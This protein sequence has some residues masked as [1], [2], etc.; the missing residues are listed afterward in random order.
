MASRSGALA[1]DSRAVRVARQPAVAGDCL[2]GSLGGNADARA[3]SGHIGN[4][5]LV[6][7]HRA[8]DST[9]LDVCATLAELK[10]QENRTCTNSSF[11]Y[12]FCFL[13]KYASK[14]HLQQSDA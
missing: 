1:S 8:G 13:G 2:I 10:Y 9:A 7:G 12:T 11:I 4:G 6:L 3:G 5:G 14:E